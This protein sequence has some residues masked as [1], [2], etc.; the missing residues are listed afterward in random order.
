MGLKISWT[1]MASTTWHTYV[2][3]LVCERTYGIPL[4]I[5][6]SSLSYD[7]CISF[8]LCPFASHPFLFINLVSLAVTKHN[9]ILN[10]YT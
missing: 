2:I 8:M 9:T 6:V 3:A 10:I 1:R 7:M 5:H 4:C